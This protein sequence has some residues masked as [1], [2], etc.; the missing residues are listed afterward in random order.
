MV[1]A[2]IRPQIRIHSDNPK[3]VH[4][5]HEGRIDLGVAE[6]DEVLGQERELEAVA[7]HEQGDGEVADDEGAG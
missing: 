4:A 1:T 3:A 6:V 5:E 2:N 7:C